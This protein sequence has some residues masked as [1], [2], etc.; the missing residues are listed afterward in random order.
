MAQLFF[1]PESP[2][3]LMS[4]G[5]YSEAY[6]SMLRLRGNELLAARDVYYIF[7]LLEE[8]AS[9]VR[10]RNRVIEMFTIGRNRRAMLASCLVMFGRK[11][12]LSLR[13][14]FVSPMRSVASRNPR[15]RPLIP[16]THLTRHLSTRTALSGHET[17]Q[18]ILLTRAEQFCGVNAIVY[19]TATI[20]TQA[21]FSDISALLASWGFGMLNWRKWCQDSRLAHASEA[22]EMANPA[23]F[24]I[25]GILTIDK[26]GRRPLLLVTFP[27]MSILLLFTG[28]CF[29]I[30]DTKVRTG[31]ITLGIYLYCM[32]YSPGEGPVPFTY[33]AEVYPLYIRELG[34]GLSTAV[35]WF[36][37]FIG[38]PRLCF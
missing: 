25:P 17:L 38:E 36:F 26:F 21:G 31:L 14:R 30:E 8:E 5:R 19:Y 2:R 11:W 28:F 10:G 12:Q 6:A 35:L 32:V 1:L 22:A 15:P 24:A 34:M 18:G 16:H 20:F 4:K 7:V 3:W 13:Y 9:I 37:N 33:S 27:L 23:V 29:W